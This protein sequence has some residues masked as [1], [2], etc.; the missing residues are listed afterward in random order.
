MIVYITFSGVTAHSSFTWVAVF[1]KLPKSLA[2]S[3]QKQKRFEFFLILS[4]NSQF[5]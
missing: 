4:G 1:Q 3:S 5:P 2:Q